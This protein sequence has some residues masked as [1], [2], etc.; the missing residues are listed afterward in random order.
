MTTGGVQVRQLLPYRVIPNYTSNEIAREARAWYPV[1]NSGHILRY[2][3][4]VHQPYQPLSAF[5]HEYPMVPRLMSPV[6]LHPHTG[7][8]SNNRSLLHRENTWSH[9]GLTQYFYELGR[10][11][12]RHRALLQDPR[13]FPAG[14]TPSAHTANEALPLAGVPSGLQPFFASNAT[15]LN[16]SPAGNYFRTPTGVA[17]TTVDFYTD[18]RPGYSAGTNLDPR[19]SQVHAPIHVSSLSAIHFFV[20]G[21]ILIPPRFHSIYR[22]IFN[23]SLRTMMMK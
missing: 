2:P 23:R 3:D 4:Y 12:L 6:H 1:E 9:G 16:E 13:S 15:T 22:S 5:F 21:F 14:V 7:M 20:H 18:I 8:M 10:D 17:R 19:K 11:D